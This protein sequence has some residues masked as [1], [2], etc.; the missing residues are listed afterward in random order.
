M[1]DLTT[2]QIRESGEEDCVFVWI[3]H[4]P[5]SVVLPTIHEFVRNTTREILEK[6]MKKMGDFD[7]CVEWLE[8]NDVAYCTLEHTSAVPQASEKPETIPAETFVPESFGH[9]LEYAAVLGFD[10]EANDAGDNDALE[11]QALDWIKARGVKVY[12]EGEKLKVSVSIIYENE[13][14]GMV[15]RDLDHL[16]RILKYQSTEKGMDISGTL[17]IGKKKK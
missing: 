12:E 17:T 3:G 1:S 7:E 15:V 13:S 10:D 5:K 16:I 8:R 6:R 14:V 11:Q 9:T 4:V 2:L